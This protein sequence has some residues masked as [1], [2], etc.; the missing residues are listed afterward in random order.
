MRI[1]QIAPLYEAVPPKLYGGTERV[2]SYLTEA[3][4]ELGHDVTLFASGDS[5]TS[6]RLEAAWPRALRLD[7]SIR[8]SMAPH[9]RLL[10]KVA[11][12]AHEFDVLHFHLDYLPFPLM[13]RLDTPYVTTLHG[14]LDLPELQPVFDAFPDAPVV[15]ISNN[16]RKPLPQAAWAG[17]VYHGLPDTLL[18]PQ[19]GVKP[20]YLAFLG[21]I[22]PEK[23]VDTAIRIAAQSGLP[24]KI[25]AKV[26]KADADYF[27]EVIE[28][29][30][31]QAHVEF[32]GEINEAQKPAFLAGAKALLFP[33]DWP[34]PFGLVMIEAMACGTPVVAFNRG[35]VP[36]VIEDG[37]TGFIVEDVQGAVGALHRIDSL[38]R[39]A[40]RERFDTR[41]SSKA[42]AQ[43]YVETYESLGTGT[44]QPAL[45][46]V[47]G[48]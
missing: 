31:G 47:A 41:F 17:T 7:P 25:A 9:M 38:S 6:A 33:I 22:C 28:P 29:L 40:I 10:E 39:T 42:M 2:V 3:L 15:S 21:R 12:V 4:V 26:D 30:L 43:R 35:S 11:R 24:L 14:R 16:Q 37:V 13:S 23:R 19:P 32:I 27:K 45:R 46:R 5:V 8:D 20:E 18:T 48:A 44:R 34:E 1:A 36:E